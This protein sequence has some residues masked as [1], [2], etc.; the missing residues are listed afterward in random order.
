VSRERCG[1]LISEKAHVCATSGMMMCYVRRRRLPHVERG[2]FSQIGW[3][4]PVD[5]HPRKHILRS[6]VGKRELNP[7]P[8]SGSKDEND[9]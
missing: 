7:N 8:T 1:M 4:C 3:L 5:S 2:I 6:G 9:T